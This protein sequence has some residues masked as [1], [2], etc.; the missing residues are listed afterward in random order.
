MTKLIINPKSK[1]A[2]DSVV[3]N[4]PQSLLITG[5]TGVGL[6]SIAQYIAASNNVTPV[7]VLPEYKEKVDLTKGI[8]GVDIIRRLYDQTR[9][10]ADNRRII[11]IDYAERMAPRAQNAF[12]KLLEEPGANTY[13][14]LATHTP[15]KL[16]PTITSRVSSVNFLPI[17]QMQSKKLLDSV[18]VSDEKKRAQLLFMAEGLPAELMR[19]TEGGEYFETRSAIVRDARELLRGKL[20]QKLLIAHTYKDD[21]PAALLLVQDIARILK[22]SIVD[23]PQTSTISHIDSV[24]NT[25]Q[26]IE[27]NGNIRLCLARL[28]V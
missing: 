14:I 26:K 12:L 1:L 17:T 19:L 9:T 25:Y 3:E 21:R 8:I 22:Q 16:L 20:Y 6:G 27:A 13:F 5:S 2:L 10:R 23:K 15:Q 24:L 7:I 11:V 18:G 4:L 28:V